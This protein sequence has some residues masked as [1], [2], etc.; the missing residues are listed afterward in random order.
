[1][2]GAVPTEVK[3]FEA[4]LV[5]SLA[6]ATEIVALIELLQVQNSTG[7]NKNISVKGAGGAGVVVRNALIARIV[8]LISRAYPKAREGDR[9]FQRAVEMLKSAELRKHYSAREANLAAAEKNWEKCRGDQR[10]NEVHHFRDKYTAH[11]GEPKD[12]PLPSFK[13]LFAVAN[14]TV[15]AIEMFAFAVGI[16]GPP[17]RENIEANKLAKAFWG[18]W[19]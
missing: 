6:E 19:G 3:S 4:L 9:H 18:P 10:T 7:I 8:L 12:I 17:V 13:D 16:Q 14:A 1:M 15:D 11:L 5:E 2:I